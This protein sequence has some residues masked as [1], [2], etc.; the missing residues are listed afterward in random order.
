MS[1]LGKEGE[2]MDL[3]VDPNGAGGD[4][5][6]RESLRLN[7]KLQDK[8]IKLNTEI[9]ACFKA[10]LSPNWEKQQQQILSGGFQ[11]STEDIETHLT[12]F[13]NLAKEL[14]TGL[15]QLKD[16]LHR[17]DESLRLKEEVT[18]L[19]EELSRKDQLIN[20]YVEKIVA[21]ESELQ[22]LKTTNHDTLLNLPIHDPTT[23]TTTS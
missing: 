4:A 3:T 20:K 21:W 2:A 5:G 6:G 17:A 10:F 7:Y 12:A 1:S 18:L 16:K 8:A 23:A 11:T 22:A 13:F 14:E 9:L 15:T 19:D